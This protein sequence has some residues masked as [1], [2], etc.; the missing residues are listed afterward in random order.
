[1]NARHQIERLL[2]QHRLVPVIALHDAEHAL[3]LADALLEG[4]LP[5]IE[6]TLRTQAAP[7]AMRHIARARA[8]R[9]TLWAGTVT[10][11][12]QAALAI[13]CGAQAIVSPGLNPRVVEYCLKH[14][15]SIVPGVCTPTE[16]E[17]ARNYGLELL[18][19]YPAEAYGGVRTLKAL[20]DVY[21]AFRFMP[22]GGINPQN[23]EDYL[24]LPIVV[25]C[26]GSWM[27]P[28]DALSAHRFERVVELVREAVTLAG[29]RGP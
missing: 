3:P 13:D 6:L 29:R 21:S 9:L 1:M 14:D 23:L 8:D 7:E 2:Q 16:I 18:K 25:A 20:S 19:F 10:S 22:T 15:L 24:K 27:A 4:G 5:I 28:A 11:A 17:L 12:E 26:G